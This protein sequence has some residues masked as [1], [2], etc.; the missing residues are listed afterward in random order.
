MRIKHSFHLAP[1]IWL[2]AL[3]LL[4]ACSSKTPMVEDKAPTGIEKSAQDNRDYRYLELD[5]GLKAVLVRDDN[6]ET[7]AVSLSI[8]AGSYQNPEAFPGLAHYLEHMLFLGTEKYPEPN[9]FQ[10]FVEA[11]A[12]RANAYTARDHTNYYV[13]LAA[14][15][16]D[17]ALDR[18]SDY[19]KAPL[20]DPEFRD[21]ERSAVHHEWSMGKSQ[22][23]RI[24]QQLMGLTANPEHPAADFHV[25]NRDTLPAGD[26]SGLQQALEDFYQRYYSANLMTLAMVSPLSLEEQEALVQKH[27]GGIPNRQVAAPGIEKPALTEEHLG[28]HIYYKPQQDIKEMLIEFP[29]KDNSDQWR[30]KPNRYVHNLLSSED[31]GTLGHYLREENLVN[32]LTVSVS[33]DFY[34]A[35]GILR[36]NL[37]LTEQGLEHQDRIIAASLSYLNLIKTQGVTREYFEEFRDLA[38]NNFANWS[39]PQPLQQAVHLSNQLRELPPAYIN[40]ARYTYERFDPEAINAVLNQLTVDRLRIWHINQ[41]VE[42]DTDIPFYEGSYRMADITDEER[43]TW[44]KEA[45]KIFLKLPQKNTLASGERQAVEHNILDMTQLVKESGLEVWFQHAEHHQDGKGYLHFVLNNNLGLNNERDLVLGNLLN[46][47]LREHNLSLIDRAG[48]AGINMSMETT[49]GNMQNLTISG[50]ADN[51]QALA[52]DVFDSIADL[53]I[54][55]TAFDKARDSFRERIANEDKQPPSQQIWKFMARTTHPYDWNQQK[56]LAAIDDMEPHHLQAYLDR[57]KQK[58]LLR[59]YAFGHYKPAQIEE[60]ARYAESKLGKGRRPVDQVHVD[61]IVTPQ[62][63]Q[64][65]SRTKPIRHSDVGWL[66]VYVLPEENDS[67]LAGFQLLSNLV[68]N[69]M[70]TQLRSEEQIGYSLGAGGFPMGDYPAFMFMV[71]S[72][73]HSLAEIHERVGRFRREYLPE[74]EALDT[75]VVEQLRQSTLAQLKQEPNNFEAEATRQLRDFYRN[76]TAFDSRENTIAALEK[77]TK[78]DLVSTYKDYILG[79]ATGRIV[80]QMKGTNFTDSEFAQPQD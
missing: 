39:A 59:V 80:L 34:G 75:Q 47:V 13:Q 12:G 4:W 43:A 67:L 2:M 56:I 74:L 29:L 52:K 24:L 65:W 9:A 31:P 33:P 32:S 71:Q 70:Y 78:E 5:N 66:D 16:L 57:V 51:H 21:K 8:N 23:P 62:P 7:A 30:L 58:S 40:S 61:P 55:Q 42:T 6:A 14:A 50:P 53:T 37:D 1:L 41:G 54:N 69:P 19:F 25:G 17:P 73:D 3:S 20:F 76:N 72:S 26:N 60:L 44:Q 11:N 48:R 77:I 35:D 27:F 22:D 64:T 10:K 46:Q 28:K 36:I 79:D 49:Q 38:Q 68:N 63:G 45:K 15:E 18:F